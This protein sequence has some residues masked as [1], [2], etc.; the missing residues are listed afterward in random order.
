MLTFFL[1][2]MGIA[3]RDRMRKGRRYALLLGFILA[4]ILTPPDPLSQLLMAL[5]LI[6]LY[7]ISIWVARIVNE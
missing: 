5:P 3:T 7:E 6:V 4:A 2:K 1:A